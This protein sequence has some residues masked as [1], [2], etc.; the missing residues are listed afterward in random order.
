[1]RTRLILEAVMFWPSERLSAIM[2]HRRHVD[3]SPV[4]A[5]SIGFFV[6]ES[7][8]TSWRARAKVFPCRRECKNANRGAQ[9]IMRVIVLLSII[10]PKL[11]PLSRKWNLSGNSKFFSNLLNRSVRNKANF[12]YFIVENLCMRQK[13]T[14]QNQQIL[15][16]SQWSNQNLF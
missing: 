10:I 1:M 2:T 11:T 13:Q 15:S 6:G 7:A 14:P 3:C 9:P 16:I 12:Y 5:T 4:V 8:M